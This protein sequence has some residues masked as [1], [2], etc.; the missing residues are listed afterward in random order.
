MLFHIATKLRSNIAM[1]S[2]KVG[3]LP[4]NS[5]I[6]SSVPVTVR[7]CA[8]CIPFVALRC[9]HK[10]SIAS[11]I[12]SVKFVLGWWAPTE[13]NLVFASTSH[14]QRWTTHP[15][16]HTCSSLKFSGLYSGYNM[17]SGE[18]VGVCGCYAALLPCVKNINFC[19]WVMVVKLNKQWNFVH[20]GTDLVCF[21]TIVL[22]VWT[23][24]NFFCNWS[25]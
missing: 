16:T 15:Q 4:R 9:Q 18:S 21:S 8:W 23:F 3:Q 6:L 13:T 7:C 24:Q 2:S 10:Q 25:D 22:R 14:M 19:H 20:N 1:F 11:L 17:Y 12:A 5:I